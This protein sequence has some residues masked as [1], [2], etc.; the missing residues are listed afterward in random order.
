L[1]LNAPSFVPSSKPATKVAESTTINNTNNNNNNN[2]SSA[3]TPM[4]SNNS[5]VVYNNTIGTTTSTNNLATI[6]TNF[7]NNFM[8]NQVATFV[9]VP[10][11]SLQQFQYAQLPH[12]FFILDF[13]NS[14]FS[15]HQ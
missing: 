1:D 7:G 12:V 2:V 14:L 6:A 10:A 15:N 13:K 9:P 8:T 3:P 11:A 5:L 4:I